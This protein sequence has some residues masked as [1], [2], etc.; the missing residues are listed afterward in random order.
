MSQKKIHEIHQK[1]GPRAIEIL[2]NHPYE[3]K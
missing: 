3:I 2:E 1:L